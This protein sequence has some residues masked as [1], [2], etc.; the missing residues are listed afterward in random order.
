MTP[1]KGQAEGARRLRQ[2]RFW[3][4]RY[5]EDPAFFG[6][7]ASAFA[8]WC[9]PRLREEAVRRVLELGAGYGRDLCYFLQMGYDAHGVDNVAEGVKIGR[10]HISALGLAKECS[11]RLSRADVVPWLR[12]QA[13]GSADAVYSCLFLN[14]DFTEEEHRRLLREVER[15]LRPGGLHLFSVRSSHDPWYGRG[16]KVGPDTFDLAPHG[17]TM[18]FFSRRYVRDLTT[19]SFEELELKEMAHGGNSFPTKVLYVVE[20]KPAAERP[21]PSRKV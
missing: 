20:R 2:A 12:R 19:G 16:R 4:V 8:R 1:R 15:V 21:R 13:S 9:E 14:M 10:E 5:R 3:T 6:A 11:R 7:G 17:T 18:H